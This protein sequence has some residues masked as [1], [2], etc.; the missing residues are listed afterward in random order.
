[1]RKING[2]ISNINEGEFNKDKNKV[3]LIPTF[4]FLKNSNSL[5]KLRIN[6]KLRIQ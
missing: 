6:T 4:S 1:M 5:N 3:K 2:N